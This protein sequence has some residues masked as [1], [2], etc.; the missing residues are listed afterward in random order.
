MR[1]TLAAVLTISLVAMLAAAPAS[2]KRAAQTVKG[3]VIK[4]EQ[5]V[6]TQNGGEYDR[7]TIRTRQ[8][9]EMRLHLGEGAELGYCSFCEGV[10]EGVGVEVDDHG[11]APGVRRGLNSRMC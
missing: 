8:G 4:V 11:P 2:A 10:G 5:H 6:R 1:K 3:H 7:L 9:E